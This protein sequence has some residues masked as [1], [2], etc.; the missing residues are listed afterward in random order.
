[1]SVYIII[2]TFE[3]LQNLCKTSD[4]IYAIGQNHNVVFYSL[5]L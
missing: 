4:V 3:A 2:L 1:V 5:W